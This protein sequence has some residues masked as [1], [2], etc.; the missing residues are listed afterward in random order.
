MC[1]FSNQKSKSFFVVEP[2][3]VDNR[4]CDKLITIESFCQ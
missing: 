4:F 3:S 1:H 2:S